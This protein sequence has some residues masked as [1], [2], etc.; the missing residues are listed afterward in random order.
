MRFL[1]KLT[2]IQDTFKYIFELS[3]STKISRSENESKRRLGWCK[4]KNENNIEYKDVPFKLEI[5]IVCD[6]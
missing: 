3:G 1:V 5:V 6:L 2:I 4:I